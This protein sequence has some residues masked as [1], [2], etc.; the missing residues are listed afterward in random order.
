MP[1]KE[2]MVC[3]SMSKLR[4]VLSAALSDN[5]AFSDGPPLQIHILRQSACHF[6]ALWHRAEGMQIIKILI[7]PGM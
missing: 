1:I 6:N 4:P 5:D 7:Y 2:Y 3:A